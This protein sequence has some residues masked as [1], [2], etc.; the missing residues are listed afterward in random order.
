MGQLYT[1]GRDQLR[2]IELPHIKG[3]EIIADGSYELSLSSPDQMRA[4]LNRGAWTRK[5]E[6]RL[7]SD[8]LERSGVVKEQM[9]ARIPEKAEFRLR[10][11]RDR[12]AT[13]YP[14]EI[15]NLPGIAII[16]GIVVESA[17]PRHAFQAINSTTI[18]RYMQN[19]TIGREFH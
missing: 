19:I 9:L 3:H 12:V 8:L 16:V 13:T 14:V 5:G 18:K 6:S 15:S 1:V 11:N 2:I 10:L 4:S 7:P 17:D